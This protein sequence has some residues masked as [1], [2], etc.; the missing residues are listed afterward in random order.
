MVD[1]VKLQYSAVAQV[2]WD[3]ESSTLGA[4]RL[5]EQTAGYVGVITFMISSNAMLV[6]LC[7]KIWLWLIMGNLRFM[8]SSRA[9]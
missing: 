3:I 8:I 5:R 9:M 6:R 7:W 4:K 2:G 1:L